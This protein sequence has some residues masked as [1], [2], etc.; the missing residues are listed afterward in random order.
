MLNAR[1]T[2]DAIAVAAAAAA[3]YS[4][5]R[6]DRSRIAALRLVVA[7]AARIGALAKIRSCRSAVR[8]ACR[9]RA[10]ADV[11]R[12]AAAAAVQLKIVKWRK[13]WRCRARSLRHLDVVE[14]I[15]SC[16]SSNAAKLRYAAGGQSVAQLTE[17]PM[18][19][20]KLS[21][22]AFAKPLL[23][24]ER[25]AMRRCRRRP[26][27][28]TKRA[29]RRRRRRR[30]L[31]RL[32]WRRRWRRL[33]APDSASHAACRRLAAAHGA[34]SRRLLSSPNDD[35]D[36]GLL[37]SASRSAAVRRVLNARCNEGGASSRLR[38]VSC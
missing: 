3:D 18:R 28:D 34:K 23:Y 19:R 27:V 21:A 36:R 35:D 17:H 15:E 13:I 14:R 7:T 5:R 10:H 4:R 37:T 38:T 24:T 2:A 33:L 8:R 26:V 16:A 12:K 31:Q 25:A 9:R 30:R 32:R 1:G 29:T 20:P 6:Y 11:G 22:V